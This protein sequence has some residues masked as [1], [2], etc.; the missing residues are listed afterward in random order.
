M[1]KAAYLNMRNSYL[2]KKLKTVFVLESPP[3]SGKYFYN[4]ESRVTEPLFAG[5]M[6]LLNFQPESKQEGLRH[7]AEAGYFLVDATY[8]PVNKL[9]KTERD[10]VI[11]QDFDELV[12]DLMNLETS[13]TSK[14]ILVKAN[15]CKLLEPKLQEKGFNVWNNGKVIPFPACGQQTKFLHQAQ[16]VLAANSHEERAD[17]SFNAQPA[18]TAVSADAPPLALRRW[19][20]ETLDE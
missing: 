10:A 6:R 18:A 15:V 1:T 5:M 19:R 2:P 12:S 14:I 20:L 16:K 7:F 4:V 9:N 8:C 11:L 3:I 17:T 13:K